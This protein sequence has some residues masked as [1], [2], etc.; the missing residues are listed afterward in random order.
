MPRKKQ[1]TRRKF[2]QSAPVVAWTARAGAASRSLASVANSVSFENEYLKLAMSPEGRI[3]TF[4]DKRSGKNYSVQ[5]AGNTVL[6]LKKDGRTHQPSRCSRSGSLLAVEFDQA[7]VKVECALVARRHYLTMEV[8]SVE[9]AGIE[10][11]TL[12]DLRLDISDHIGTMANLAWNEE[13]AACV[14][15]LNLQTNAFG[16]SLQKA[17]LWS[18][19]YPKFGLVGAKIGL[20]GCP[21][22]KVRSVIKEMVMREG[23]AQSE[24]GGAWALDAEENRY[25]YLFSYATERDVD[26]W[27]AMARSG[28]FKQLLVSDIGPYGHYN[29]YPK[30]YP[31]GLDGVQSVVGKIHAAGLKA[32][33]HML[34]FTIQKSDPWVSPVPNKYL[35]TGRELTLAATVSAE[36]TFI[37]TL[38][39]PEGLPI[40][41]GFWFRGGRDIV[42]GDEI[43][44]YTG[45]QTDSPYGLTGCRRGANGTRAVPH[46]KGSTLR[47]LKE[48]F[49]T[50]VPEP[51]SPLMQQMVERIAHI[52]NYCRFDMM[53]F[54]GLDGADV[55]AGREW[56]WHYGPRFALSI[57]HR[58]KRRLQVEASAWY[59]HDWHITSRLGAWD[60]PV[61]SP[62]R[63]IDLHIA[64]NRKLNDLIPTQLGWWAFNRYKPRLALATTPDVVEYLMTKSLANNSG[65]SLE[66]ITPKTLRENP[67]WSKLLSL[68]GSFEPLR[69]GGAI[70]ESLKARLRVPGHEY[71]FRHRADGGAEFVPVEYPE[72]KVTGLDGVNNAFQIRNRFAAQQPGFRI[73]AL[74]A[75]GPYEAPQNIVLEDF[76]NPADLSL[77]S[78][79]SGVTMELGL[80]SKV[81]R[82]GFESGVLR[83]KNGG[84][85]RR[86]AWARLGKRFAPPLDISRQPAL[87][88]WIN[89]D[90]KG[91]V[92]NFQLLDPRGESVA[93]GEHYA[94]V[95]FT[96]WRYFELVEPEGGRWSDYLWPY[97]SALAAYR[98]AVND[99]EIVE[100]NI[101][102]NNLP[103]GE[104]VTCYLSPIRAL[105]VHKAK[106]ERPQIQCAGK[107]LVFPVTLESGN[108][109]EF[110]PS[111]ECRLF[112]PNGVFLQDVT[113]EGEA[114]MIEPG[115]NRLVFNCEGAAGDRPRAI[116]TTILK[117][118]ALVV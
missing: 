7:A 21:A 108:Y 26:D 28:G 34:A 74:L 87:G 71:A 63:F 57:F 39:S 77:R 33:W 67:T 23:F 89:G 8:K 79:Q 43:L 104:S 35:A 24:V 11:L 110:H 29:P 54:D 114:P 14:M 88:V 18:A 75:A 95:D 105:P 41:S 98:E 100:L 9:G 85:S 118:S 6:S 117:G 25:S 80:S 38:Q 42:V 78:S 40:H 76:R 70:P 81:V 45:L 48:V 65:I 101:Y 27:I 62:K 60:H 22:T 109:L 91:E 49:A 2:L 90:G 93:I 4:T 52:A 31:H 19:C 47:N 46:A 64:A 61:R 94:I 59:H 51:D 1:F 36:D 50:Y 86:G 72:H 37:P 17:R 103:P 16:R 73:R 113:P 99:S 92:L 83:A 68:M 58:V 12:S 112:D 107:R 13:F 106:L 30:K 97:H 44:T 55:F 3:Q 20:V 56:S 10:E 5:G 15:A 115:E 96:G 53:Y 32:G 102:Y 69:K 84:P 111:G 116:V 66:E 82:K